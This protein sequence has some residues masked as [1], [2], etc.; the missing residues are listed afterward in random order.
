MNRE[1]L[2]VNMVPLQ[3]VITKGPEAAKYGTVP[4]IITC[5]R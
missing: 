5:F 1:G 3:G 2:T 4:F